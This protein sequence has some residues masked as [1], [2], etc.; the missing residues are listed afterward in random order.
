M[1]NDK[2]NRIEK[3]KYVLVFILNR[4]RLQWIHLPLLTAIMKIYK[5]TKL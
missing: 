4:F 5:S 1:L 2:S 3:I